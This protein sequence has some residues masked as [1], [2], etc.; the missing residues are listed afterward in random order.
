[1]RRI[2]NQKKTDVEAQRLKPKGSPSR[3]R[4]QK[5]MSEL[6]PASDTDI[7]FPDASD[8][9]R[10]NVIYR[11][12]QGYYEGGEFRFTFEI[13][14]SFPHDAPKVLCSQTIYH[15][16]IDVEGHVC[17]NVLREDWN[18]VLNIQSVIFGLKMLFLEPNPE[19]PLNKEAALLMIENKTRF[20]RVVRESMR[21]EKI[22]GVS[23][24]NVMDP[25]WKVKHLGA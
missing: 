13:T 12:A 1:M 5:D 23:Y 24:Q 25:K 9:T 4:L 21:G 17:L 10:F 20:A 22:G 11:P 8:P 2:W 14:D 15:P 16:N 3:I 6:E 7:A 18:P 19:D